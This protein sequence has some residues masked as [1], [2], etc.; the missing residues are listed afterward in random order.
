MDLTSE[1][2]QKILD[3]ANPEIHD[4]TDT[5]DIQAR[6]STKPLQ[7]VQAAPPHMPQ[8]VDVS[9]LAGFH[10]LITARLEDADFQGDFIIHIEDETTVTLK[11]RFSDDWGRRLR[12]IKAKPVDFRQFK[13]DQWIDQEAF[14]IAIASLFAASEDKEYVLRVAS[15]L[16]NDASTL[17][18]DDGFSQKVNVKAGLSHKS[19]VTLKPR[20]ALAPFRTFPEV[21]QPVSEFVLRAKCD[22]EGKP[23]LMLVEADGGRWKIEAIAELRKAME[24]FG[25]NIPII[26]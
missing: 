24:A 13:F 20:V 22:G 26:A 12:L 3:V 14:V 16:T 4:I 10:D 5:H 23:C 21:P 8:N 11:E 25:L 6:F 9:T 7:Q 17:S 15:S 1:M 2:I 18:E 19:S